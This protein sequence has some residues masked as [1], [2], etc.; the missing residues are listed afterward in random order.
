MVSAFVYATDDGGGGKCNGGNG[1]CNSDNR[2]GGRNGSHDSNGNGGNENGSD[3]V[4]GNGGNWKG[5]NGGKW[6]GNGNDHGGRGNGNYGNVNEWNAVDE[7]GISDQKSTSDAS[8][9]TAV[10]QHMI[11]TPAVQASVVVLLV[12]YSAEVAPSASGT[13]WS[14]VESYAEGLFRKFFFLSG[15]IGEK[16]RRKDVLRNRKRREIYYFVVNNPFSHFRRI[17]R[18]VR[19]G[20]NQCSW[21]LRILEKMGLIKSEH[22][23][24]YLTYHANNSDYIGSRGNRPAT[25]I[26]NSNATKIL[27]YLLRNPGVKIAH[28]SQALMMNR[29]TISYHIKR[30]QTNGLVERIERNGLRLSPIAEEHP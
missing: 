27:E 14:V 17:T 4:N 19:V 13:W 23:G 18:M 10:V 15:S 8:N 30:M 28:L 22:V 25:L 9:K 12:T 2:N 5:G 1:N 24:R 26:S 6:N 7:T 3:S 16:I 29:H 20:P 21:H 11:S